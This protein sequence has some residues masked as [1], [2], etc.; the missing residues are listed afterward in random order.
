MADEKTETFGDVEV[1]AEAI[2]PVEEIVE[3]PVQRSAEAVHRAKKERKSAIAKM[4][5]EEFPDAKKTAR[6]APDKS[7]KDDQAKE[8]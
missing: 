7:A 1:P 2:A 6:K 5:A 3:A 4:M 8:G